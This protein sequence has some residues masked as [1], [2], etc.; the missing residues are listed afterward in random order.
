MAPGAPESKAAA[1]HHADHPGRCAEGAQR[2]ARGEIGCRIH[3]VRTET[4]GR[5]IL[6]LV[7]VT[8]AAAEYSTTLSTPDSEWYGVSRVALTDGRV[9]FSPE[10]ADTGP[11]EWLVDA[12]RAALRVAWRAAQQPGAHFPRRI[13]RWRPAP[14]GP[15]G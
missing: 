12:M 15:S 8:G 9:D 2:V 4:G 13:Q 11:P 1:G 3:F 10:R 7:Q 6:R 5:L 14:E